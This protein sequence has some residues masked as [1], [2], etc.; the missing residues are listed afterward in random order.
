MAESITAPVK[1]RRF[2][3][4]DGKIVST[5]TPSPQK[6]VESPPPTNKEKKRNSRVQLFHKI[7]EQLSQA[8]P[9][10]FDMKARRP[11][12]VGVKEALAEWA[13]EQN[14]EMK[15]LGY[16]LGY[17]TNGIAYLK[18][19]LKQDQRVN[20]QGEPVSEVTKEHKTHAK[21]KLKN[22]LTKKDKHKKEQK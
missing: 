15:D 11:L 12:M 19:I 6:K 20:L 5:K 3:L 22:I 16:A 7:L 14:I 18:A 4:V 17:Y 9:Q 1:K 10:A 13:S 21:E 8:Y 2:K